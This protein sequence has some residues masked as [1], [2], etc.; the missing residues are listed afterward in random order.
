MTYTVGDA[1]YFHPKYFVAKG[2][3]DF[4]MNGRHVAGVWQR[5]SMESRTVF[6]GPDGKEMPL[7]RGRTLIIM[8][9][10]NAPKKDSPDR[11]YYC[12]YQ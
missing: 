10:Y 2:N 4:F 3:A 9:P 7:Q 1:W 11:V 8:L 6:Y 12:E 5:D